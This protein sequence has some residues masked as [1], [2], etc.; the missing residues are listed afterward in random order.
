M[1]WLIFNVSL[2]TKLINSIAKLKFVGFQVVALEVDV[3]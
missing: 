2:L 3:E 1:S